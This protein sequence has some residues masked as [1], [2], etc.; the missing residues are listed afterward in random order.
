MTM[1]ATTPAG[2]RGEAAR[3]AGEAR[4]GEAPSSLVSSSK[5]GERA[6][7]RCPRRGSTLLFD[8]NDPT[9]W[10]EAGCDAY[11][12]PWCGPRKARQ[13]SYGVTWVTTQVKRPRFM[14][15]TQVTDGWQ[16]AR[17]E[18]K[19]M[20]RRLRKAG[21]RTEWAW[22]LE[23]GSKTG[24]RHLHAVQHGDYVPQRE[25]QDLWGRRV[26]VRT[27]E[28]QKAAVAGYIAKGAGPVVKYLTKSAQDDYAAWLELNGGRPF[29]SSR[30]FF[31]GLGARGAVKA[32]REA[33]PGYMRTQWAEATSHA[34]RVYMDARALPAEERDAYILARLDLVTEKSRTLSGID[35]EPLGLAAAI[36]QTSW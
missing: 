29:H 8:V 33:Q 28:P 31:L 3:G 23:V 30:G 25:L 35:E 20:A 18:V 4:G 1:S 15:L 22:T 2:T 10:I 34:A 24:M 6:L 32:A 36:L 5:T 19:D 16:P 26:D 7:A 21:Y 11:M 17:E 9:R 14:T 12:C 27:A 13:F